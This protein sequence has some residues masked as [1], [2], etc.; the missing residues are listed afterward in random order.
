MTMCLRY[1]LLN[2]RN[3]KSRFTLV[4]SLIFSIIFAN[5]QDTGEATY[6]QV[7]A[8]CHTIGGGK[9]I[10]PDLADVQNRHTEQW[11]KDFIKSSQTVIKSGDKYADSLFK[12]YNQVPMPDHPNLTDDQMN[13]ILAYI[14]EKSTSPET[15]TASAPALA[16]NSE[17]GKELFIGNTRFANHGAACSSC[18]NVEMNGFTQGGA[19]A[20]D[21]T[22]TVT[23][24]SAAGVGG[25]V[26][27]LPFPQM[28][29]TY[30]TRPV[31]P[32]EIAD[33]VAFLT[34]ADRQ[35]ATIATTPIGNFL[36]LA[37]AVGLFILLILYS[38]Y[39]SRRK[40]G[41]VNFII[42]NRQMKSA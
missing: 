5:A 36:L 19:L 26:S 38:I 30:A 10:G 13:G 28:K 32:Q 9:L 31:T 22:H 29:V 37:G 11:I 34:I 15:T 39:W 1:K 7:C 8:V 2:I 23:R 24:L 25:V 4:L 16:G 6:K 27:G 3:M 40:K 33:L 14:K 21:L 35:D 18:H 20:I 41:P 12:A 42:F 17:R